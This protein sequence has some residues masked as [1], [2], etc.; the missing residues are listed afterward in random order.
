MTPFPVTEE[1]RSLIPGFALYGEDFYTPET[2]P[3]LYD[4][5]G[6]QEPLT[7]MLDNILLPIVRHWVDCFRHFGYLI[8]PHGQNVLIEVDNT[9]AI[10]RIVHRDL[11]VGIDMRRRNDLGLCSDNLNSYNRMEHS[12]FHSIA[13]D[14]F[15]GNHFFTG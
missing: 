3:L 6:D 7:F 8:E 9:M 1:N 4:L 11:S 2:D 15:M 14:R 5:I 13:Y 12:A 10:K